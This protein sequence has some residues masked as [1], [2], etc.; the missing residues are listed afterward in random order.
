MASNQAF[1]RIF[2]FVI[3]RDF[4]SSFVWHHSKNRSGFIAYGFRL[5][6][7]MSKVLFPSLLKGFSVLEKHQ[8]ISFFECILQLYK[9]IERVFVFVI[10]APVN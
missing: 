4:A 9:H 6:L 1:H 2:V 8:L 5:R 10:H 7:K 3:R